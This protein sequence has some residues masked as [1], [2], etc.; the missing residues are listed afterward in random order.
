MKLITKTAEP[1]ELWNWL[2]ANLPSDLIAYKRTDGYG[3]TWGITIKER[4]MPNLLNRWFGE[5]IALVD[6]AQL[7][8]Q[9]PNWTSDFQDLLGRY[10]KTFGIETTLIVCEESSKRREAKP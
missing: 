5:S 4:G 6:D 7:E 10:E 3:Y 8:L 9:H 1:P 2:R